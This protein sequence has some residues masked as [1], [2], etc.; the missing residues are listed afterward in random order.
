M[1]DLRQNAVEQDLILPAPVDC[2]RLDG[3]Q[4]HILQ[5][6]ANSFPQHA[7]GVDPRAS[8]PGKGPRPTRKTKISAQSISGMVRRKLRMALAVR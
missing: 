8:T 1:Q 4:V 3:L 2:R 6:L 7:A 5:H